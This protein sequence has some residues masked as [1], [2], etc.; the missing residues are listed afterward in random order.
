M[1]NCE[2]KKIIYIYGNLHIHVCKVE[3][4]TKEGEKDS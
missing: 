2:S 4:H 1:C 3:M